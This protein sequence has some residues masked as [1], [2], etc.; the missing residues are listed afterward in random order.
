M[1]I[2]RRPELD[3]FEATVR[4]RADNGK[5]EGA[6]EQHRGQTKAVRAYDKEDGFDWGWYSY[7]E[8]AIEENEKSNIGHLDA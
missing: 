5:C 3:K 8:N 1:E 7:C 4:V 6:C 2:K